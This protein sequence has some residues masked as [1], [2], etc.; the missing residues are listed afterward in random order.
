M[1]TV[2][3]SFQS[4]RVTAELDK[5]KYNLVLHWFREPST[6]WLSYTFYDVHP[7]QSLG[8]I[9]TVAYMVLETTTV[10]VPKVVSTD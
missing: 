3:D 7:N 10:T 5:R 6:N 8:K 9:P 2:I 1:E 4:F